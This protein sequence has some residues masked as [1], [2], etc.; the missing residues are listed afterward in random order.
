[1]KKYILGYTFNTSINVSMIDFKNA[2]LT[3]KEILQVVNSMEY[4]RCARMNSFSGCDIT[5]YTSVFNQEIINNTVRQIQNE[6][7]WMC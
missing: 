4:V 2:G 1:M 3:D 7:N 5:F 6:L